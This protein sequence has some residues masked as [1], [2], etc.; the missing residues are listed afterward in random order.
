MLVI[1]IAIVLTIGLSAC[2]KEY[3]KHDDPFQIEIVEAVAP[4][5]Q[6]PGIS[7][8]IRCNLCGTMLSP[9]VPI[10]ETI[11]CFEGEWIIDREATIT[12]DGVKH[13]ECIMCGKKMS[14]A[15]ISLGSQNLKYTVS[16]TSCI[17]TGAGN[18]VDLDI[19]IP[20]E[21]DGYFVTTIAEGAFEHCTSRKSVTIRNSVRSIGDYAFS[22]CDGLRYIVI[23]NN[24]KNI[25][26]LAFYSCTSLTIINFEGTIKQWNA[27]NKGDDWDKDTG[28]YTIYCTDGQIAKDGT[29]TYN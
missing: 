23:G 4:T 2:S 7:S 5:C 1:T 21:I 25:G 15:I 13:T 28:N 12:E 3:C 14:Y 17:I 27:I 9:Q 8:G 29:V 22:Y 16:D 24:V 18:C 19:V 11:E 6:K 26:D 10:L 20:S